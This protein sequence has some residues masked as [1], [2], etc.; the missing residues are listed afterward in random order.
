M[1]KKRLIGVVTVRNGWAVQSVG[2]RRYMPLGKPEMLIENL[3][4][5]GADEILVQCIDRTHA[6]LGPDF[7]LLKRVGALCL[8]TPL[9]YGGGIRNK[10]DGV[11]AVS[12]GADRL[13]LDAMLWDAPERLETLSREL[14]TQA[15]IA[16]MPV[17]SQ[18][19]QL[20]LLN[21]RDGQEC[22]LNSACASRMH[23]DWVSE[24]MLT[25]WQH[26]GQQGGFD[27]SIPA[28]FPL[29]GKPLLVFGGLSDP[30]Q[31]QQ[32]LSNANVVAAAV[33]NFLSHKEHAI[34]RLKKN[35]VGIPM[36]AAH[37]EKEE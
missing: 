27:Q 16:H 33:G 6:Q 5:W 36:R 21:Y 8:S 35:V 31:L 18:G 26:E 2:Y 3:D 20:T 17:R 1:L 32:V 23:L 19:H 11:R 14:G 25:D 4:R 24:V 37:Y 22:T 7:D 9:I 15:L 29:A 28:N 12:L 30:V 34:Q 10:D 13:T